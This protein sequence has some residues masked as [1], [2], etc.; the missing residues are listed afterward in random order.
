MIKFPAKGMRVKCLDKVSGKY[1]C[2][3]TIRRINSFTGDI[4]VE[5]DYDGAVRILRRAGLRMVRKSGRVA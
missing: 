2:V 4:E 5:F 1:G 3:G